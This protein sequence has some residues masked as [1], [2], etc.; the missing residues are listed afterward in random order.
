MAYFLG[1]LVGYLIGGMLFGALFS[2]I[3]EKLAFKEKEPDE[4][5]TATVGV[6]WLIMCILAGFG[7]SEGQGFAWFAGLYY[8]PGAA[9]VWLWYR[10]RYRKAWSNEAE[11]FD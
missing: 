9:I 11:E 5:A 7:F 6:A 3:I 2:A 8:L 4:R 10:K 1:S